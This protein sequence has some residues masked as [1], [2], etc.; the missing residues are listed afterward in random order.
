MGVVVQAGDELIWGR[1]KVLRQDQRACL[2]LKS[3]TADG[4]ASTGGVVGV[5]GVEG[6]VQVL[7]DGVRHQGTEAVG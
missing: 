7:V 1:D 6:T 2:I 3:G 4:Q 5:T